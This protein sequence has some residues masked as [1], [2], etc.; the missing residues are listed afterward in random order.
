M[1]AIFND[2]TYQA[3][4]FKIAEKEGRALMEVLE[5]G[6]AYLEELNTQNHPIADAVGVTGA[7]YIL[8]RGYEKVIDVQPEEMKKLTRLARKHPIAFVMTHKTYIDMFVLGVALAQYGIPVPHIFAGINMSFA[9]LGQFGRQAGVIFLRR[10]FKDNSVYKATLRHYIATRV[11]E[12]AH[13]MWAIEGTRSRTGKL[14]W[15]KMGILK[16]IGEGAEQ[17]SKEVKYVPVSIVYDLIPDVKSMTE[18][19]RGKTKRAE[20]LGWFLNYVRKMN[21]NLGRISLRIGDPVHISDEYTSIVPDR[22]GVLKSEQNR[23]PKFAFELVH[24]INEITPVT[25]TSLICTALLSKFAL[26]KRGLESDVAGMMQFIESRQ[27]DALVDRG[28]PIGS[29][30]QIA[31]NLLLQSGIVMRTGESLNAKYTMTA[32]YYLQATYYANMSVHQLYHQ[33]FIELA[34]LKAADAPSEEQAT[35]FWREVMDLRNLFKFEFFYSHK[36]KFT[37]EMEADLALIHPDWESYLL[38]ADKDILDLLKEQQLAVSQVVLFTYVEAYRVIAFALLEWDAKKPFNEKELIEN[39][40]IIGKELHWRGQIRR[41]EAVSKPFL[42]NGLRLAKNRQLIPTKEDNKRDKI[43]AFIAQLADVTTRINTIQDIV[44]DKANQKSPNVPIEWDIVPGSK[45][46][47]IT[48]EIMEGE[49]GPHIGAF[50]DLDRTLISGFSAK[51]FFQTHLLSGKMTAKQLIAQFAGVLVYASGYGNF[52]SLAATGAQGVKGI[53]EREFI[54]LGEDV[55]LKHLAGAIFPESRALVAAHLAKGHTVAIVSAATPYQV[56][57]VARDL[58]IEHVMCTRME[59]NNGK[60]TGRIVE[61]ACWGEGKAYAAKELQVQFDLDLNKSYFY[62]DSAEDMP[63]MEIVGNPRPLNP[64]TKLA[65]VAFQN[66]WPIYR[67]E[68]RRNFE[69][70]TMART[71]L[72]AGSLIPAVA[73]GVISGAMNLSWKDGVN[74][75]MGSIGDL[76]L[77]T[78]GVQLVVKGEHNLWEHRPAV[79]IANHQ[80][81]ADIYIIPKLLRKNFKGI[82]KKE[83]ERVPIVGQLM[84]ATGTIFIDRSNRDQAIEAMKPAVDALKGGTSIMIFPEGTRSYDYTLG[85]FKKGAFH[86]AMQAGVPIIPI[87]I[88]NAHDV[89]PRGTAF[90]RSTAVEIRVLDPVY[91]DNWKAEE[92][93]ERI[94]EVRQLFLEELGQQV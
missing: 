48:R 94:G 18:E 93:S 29:S 85:K 69:T 20:S 83:L 43:E 86:L 33:A 46:E 4:L 21:E 2:K 77:T 1:D 19:G 37:D 82:A 27:P 35:E 6:K 12:G 67:F 81:G 78:A 70:S 89:Q 74:T 9:G 92:L 11:N 55:Y 62:T 64:D 16:Y 58:A 15:P 47:G 40:Y 65:A 61:P 91:T 80:S 10:S 14:V 42:E 75:M 52:A 68:A 90:L 53:D 76:V 32:D 8:S 45:T 51:E 66:D 84:A 30:V 71:A 22:E 39:C 36:V 63:L 23:L 72:A 73:N 31:L 7:Q 88:L 5:E 79:F 54:E 17:A 41:M 26:T 49:S 44:F 3:K 60:F 50:F 87:V 25:T 59:V 38:E 56:N 34:F 28:K 24:R 13:F 57:P